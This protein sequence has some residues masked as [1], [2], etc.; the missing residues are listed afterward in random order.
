MPIN[1]KPVVPGRVINQ[2]NFQEV[3]NDA[4]HDD[5]VTLEEAE[6]ILE[7]VEADLNSFDSVQ[8]KEAQDLI[9]LVGDTNPTLAAMAVRTGNVSSFRSAMSVHIDSMLHPQRE[10]EDSHSIEN[11]RRGIPLDSSEPLHISGPEGT[12]FLVGGGRTIENMEVRMRPITHSVHGDGYETRFKVTRKAGN[13]I[14]RLL[15][16]KPDARLVE[17]RIRDYGVREDGAIRVHVGDDPLSQEDK[18]A[19][20]LVELTAKVKSLNTQYTKL[21]KKLETTEPEKR[22]EIETQIT[23]L[24]SQIKEFTT[25]IET[26]SGSS[27]YSSYSYGSSDDGMTLGHCIRVDEPGK[28]RIDYFPE[29]VSKQAL[30]GSVHI[31]AYGATEEEKKANL[32]EAVT[33]LEMN[34]EL[35]AEPS[36]ESMENLRLMRLLWQASPTLASKMQKK[37]NLTTDAIREA[38][39]K[40]KV[41]EDFIE[42]ARFS[43]VVPG[44]I[45]VVVPGQ[46][47]AYEAAGVTGLIHT[48]Q[49]ID[50]I[51]DI[52]ADGALSATQERLAM[53]KVI[54]GMSSATD[55]KTGGAEYVF[56]RLM[57][58]KMGNPKTNGAVISFNTELLDRTDWFAYPSDKYGSTYM[59]SE[60]QEGT[61][62]AAVKKIMKRTNP[63]AEAFLDKMR[64]VQSSGQGANSFFERPTGRELIK[65]IN[66]K[67]YASSSVSSTRN[68]AMFQGH[69]PLSMMN[70]ILVRNEVEQKKILTQLEEREITEI[71]GAPAT[72]FI[73]VQDTLFP[74]ESENPVDYPD[75]I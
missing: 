57:T 41:P 17:K 5:Q 25:S 22:G 30:R 67:T 54:K 55:L 64:S 8:V 46:A 14:E 4:A 45:Y 61:I 39:V 53:R 13:V 40:A 3:L 60:A 36:E 38:L 75:Y 35:Q 18:D 7:A 26:L 50:K 1:H 48:I 70:Y 51:A 34:D 68:E 31:E 62:S 28:F 33:V 49:N 71:N 44:H 19:A 72:E 63:D 23:E 47:E 9:K 10:I 59:R 20:Q 74:P 27:N 2:G 56:T 6:V 69:I 52:I 43:E 32:K 42:E 58:K 12:A 37:T 65:A 73:R 16:K 24:K 29:E 21:S 66:D 11:V 15:A